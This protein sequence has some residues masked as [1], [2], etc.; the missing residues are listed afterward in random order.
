MRTKSVMFA[1][2]LALAGALAACQSGPAQ[3]RV[4]SAS[5]S[6][7]LA[8]VVTPENCPYDDGPFGAPVRHFGNVT[9]GSDNPFLNPCWPNSPLSVSNLLYG[10]VSTSMTIAAIV[11]A[12]R[13]IC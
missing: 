2:T 9:P 1:L 4:A 12:D 6:A 10:D 3:Q 8:P 13:T 11:R 7:Y 5:R